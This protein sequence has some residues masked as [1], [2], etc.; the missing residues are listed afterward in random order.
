MSRIYCR[1]LFAVAIL[2]SVAPVESIAESG[3]ARPMCATLLTAEELATAVVSGF[4][5][6]GAEESDPGHS[7]CP[8]MLR[9]DS[10][11][12][13]VSVQ[14]TTLGAITEDEYSIEEYFNNLVN[15]GVGMGGEKEDLPNIGVRAAFIPTDPQVLAIVQRKDGVARI[16]GNNLTKEQITNVAKAVAE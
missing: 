16:V 3:T 6:M 12:K 13:T 9:G 14:F 1:I 4:Q 8:W 2:L 15:A 10:G 7:S 11:F 5:D